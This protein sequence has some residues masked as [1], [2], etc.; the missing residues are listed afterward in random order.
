MFFGENAG[1][2]I[3]KVICYPLRFKAKVKEIGLKGT[4]KLLIL[5]GKNG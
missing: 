4:M 3:S 1:G 2:A 5:G